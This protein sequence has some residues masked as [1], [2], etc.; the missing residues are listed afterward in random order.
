MEKGGGRA[1]ETYNSDGGNTVLN[2]P[3]AQG[4]GGGNYACIFIDVSKIIYSL[5]DVTVR[6]SGNKAARSVRRT[7]RGRMKIRRTTA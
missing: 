1:G 7:V 6:I 2:G 4:E 3:A 5:C